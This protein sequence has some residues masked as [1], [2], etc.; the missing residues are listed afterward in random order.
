MKA[1]INTSNL[2]YFVSQKLFDFPLVINNMLTAEEKRWL[3]VGICLSKVLT[4][5]LRKV[6]EQELLQLYQNLIQP[7]TNIQSQTSSSHH[8]C[9]PPSTLRLN[10]VNINNNVNQASHHSYDYSVKDEVSLAK[11]FV[12]PFMAGF[13]SFDE[14]LDSSAALSILCGA[15]NF[16][17]LGIDIIAMDVR[18]NVRNEWGHCKFPTWSEA[19]YLHCFQLMENLIKRLNLPATFEAK[20]LEDFKEWRNRGNV[21]CICNAT[22]QCAKVIKSWG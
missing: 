14:S 5:A 4:P 13:T 20:V 9:L 7:P 19:Y 1:S 21:P 18:N 16:V 17:F 11:L 8:K 15:P 22:L 12:K 3:V 6:I 2:T 10:Y